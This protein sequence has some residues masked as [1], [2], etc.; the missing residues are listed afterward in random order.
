MPFPLSSGVDSSRSVTQL[1]QT[2]WLSSEGRRIKSIDF[3][4]ALGA[5]RRFL[6]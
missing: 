4:V 2:D 1:A 6:L 5:G 3:T